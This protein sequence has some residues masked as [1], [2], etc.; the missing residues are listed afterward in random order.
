MANPASVVFEYTCQY[1][2]LLEED[3]QEEIVRG[4]PV[5]V[6]RGSVVRKYALLGV[7]QAH[8][9]TIRRALVDMQCISILRQ[10]GRST[11]SVLVLH[12]EPT[13]EAWQIFSESDLT[14]HLDHAIL[15]QKI[16]DIGKLL[17][18][19]RVAEALADIVIRLEKV[20]REVERIGKTPTARRRSASK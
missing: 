15:T 8:Y 7:S 4:A 3:A 20:E 1:Y 14:P 13:P 5:S 9:S 2:K 11:D 16:E 18:G 10:G 17:G 6:F 12:R 19:I